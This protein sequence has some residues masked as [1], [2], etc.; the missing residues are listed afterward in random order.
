L[1]V[2]AF[3]V[4]ITPKSPQPDSVEYARKALHESVAPLQ[5]VTEILFAGKLDPA[6][7]NFL[8]RKFMEMAKIPAGDFREWDVIAAWARELP[9]MFKI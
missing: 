3:A 8:M 6:K 9:G 1:P 5:P 2:A 7:I 4:G